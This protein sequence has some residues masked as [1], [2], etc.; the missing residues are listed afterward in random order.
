MFKPVLQ[1]RIHF[2]GSLR[3]QDFDSVGAVNEN[4]R[5]GQAFA[6]KGNKVNLTGGK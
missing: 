1:K 2:N 4:T 6:L 5:F 3:N